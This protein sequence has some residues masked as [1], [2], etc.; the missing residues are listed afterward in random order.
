MPKKK[1]ESN[2]DSIDT[3]TLEFDFGD[4]WEGDSKL[5]VWCDGRDYDA[6]KEIYRPV[7]SYSIKTPKWGYDANDIYGAPNELP[8]LGLASKS[9]F[10]FLLQCVEA[11]EGSEN[12]D[13]FPPQV[14]DWANHFSDRLIIEYTRI[15]E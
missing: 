4:S 2:D 12:Y 10:A 1:I 6:G 14:R 3:P 7:Y 5:K 8:D 9:L 13:L 15:T 11:K